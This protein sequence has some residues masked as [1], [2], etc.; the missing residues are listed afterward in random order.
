MKI[1]HI[2]NITEI[3]DQKKASNLHI[4]QPVTMHS[5]VTAKES[6]EKSVDVELVA[7]W[8]YSE[9]IA[10]LPEFKIA[11]QLEKY[12]W[13]YIPSLRNHPVKPLPRLAD[14]INNHFQNTDADYL[15]YTN[16]DI[17]LYPGFYLRVK[18][19]I[20]KGYDALCINRITLP[21]T[22][23]GHQLDETN[24][25]L[26]YGIDG[27]RHPGIDCFIFKR[28]IVP[29]LDLGNVVIGF[30][31]IG[32]VLK[33]QIEKHSQ[34]FAWIKN[35]RLTFHLGNDQA[36]RESLSPYQAAN[37]D[38][39]SGRYEPC[40]KTSLSQRIRRKALKIIKSFDD[41]EF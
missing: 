21:E 13:E 22:F 39:A 40:L 1:S 27:E 25:M 28:K 7:I 41:E 5:M 14:I 36:W 17:G 8:H 31:P 11:P 38:A 34:N 24:M 2:I 4:A 12:G 9:Q 16:L 26:I 37:L 29:Q 6:A 18:E 33:H 15:I 23:S 32:M 19:L 35:E 10:P 30:P 20:E 3:T